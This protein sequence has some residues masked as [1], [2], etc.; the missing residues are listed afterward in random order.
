MAVA[1]DSLAAQRRVVVEV[2]VAQ[3]QLPPT[4]QF[5]MPRHLQSPSAQA[6][7]AVWRRRTES[8]EARPYW[9]W[10]EVLQFRP[11]VV[12]VVR[13]FPRRQTRQARVQAMAVL[14]TTTLSV[15]T[16]ETAHPRRSRVQRLRTQ[17]VAAAGPV[18]VRTPRA[19]AAQAVV[20]QVEA[21][22]QARMAPRILVVAVAAAVV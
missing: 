8:L 11:R 10:R 16:A 12:T 21:L 13:N 4:S 22:V 7:L 18:R 2:G 17:V 9:Q 6:V 20:V 19:P 3:W 14:A 1:V 15:P 5:P